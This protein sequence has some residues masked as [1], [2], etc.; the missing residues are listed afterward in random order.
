MQDGGLRVGGAPLGSH[1]S[2]RQCEERDDRDNGE[3]QRH[4]GAAASAEPRSPG[5]DQSGAAMR[6]HLQDG[7]GLRVQ[8]TRPGQRGWTA[9]EHQWRAVR[10]AATRQ[11]GFA[12]RRRREGR[13]PQGRSYPGSVSSGRILVLFHLVHVSLGYLSRQRSFVRITSCL[14]L[15]RECVN[16]D[17]TIFDRL[18][19]CQKLTRHSCNWMANT[20]RREIRP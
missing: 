20:P 8:R 11:R 1:E 9:A 17:A 3:Q 14:G 5:P 12:A 7:D 15:D 6:H 19:L 4:A 13:R 16:F 10:T 18:V 2:G